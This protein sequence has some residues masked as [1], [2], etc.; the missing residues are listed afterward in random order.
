MKERIALRALN[1]VT[2]E[3]G[4]HLQ[5]SM[6]FCIDSTE[7]HMKLRLALTATFLMVGQFLVWSLRSHDVMS[8]HVSRLW[9]SEFFLSYV[10]ADNR[11]KQ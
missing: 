8:R 6:T 5:T 10:P 3:V 11:N 4:T 9:C 1:R 2:A 7:A